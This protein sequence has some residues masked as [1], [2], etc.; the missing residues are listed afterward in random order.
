MTIPG[1]LEKI[2]AEDFLS[3]KCSR[4]RWIN[5]RLQEEQSFH[6]KVALELETAELLNQ[7]CGFVD[8]EL[9]RV[10]PVP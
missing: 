6:D 7:L 10:S 3:Y 9:R 5:K 1:N 2:H 4:L 8:A